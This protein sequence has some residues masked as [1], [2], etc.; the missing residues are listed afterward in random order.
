MTSLASLYVM[1]SEERQ[2]EKEKLKKKSKKKENR[3]ARLTQKFPRF[4]KC[5]FYT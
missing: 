4:P 1:Q 2:K 5:E 3:F